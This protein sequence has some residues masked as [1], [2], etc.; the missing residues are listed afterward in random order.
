[1]YSD[2]FSNSDYAYDSNR[3]LFKTARP[4]T[5][6]ASVEPLADSDTGGIAP[7]TDGFLRTCKLALSQIDIPS[8]KIAAL[9][10]MSKRVSDDVFIQNLGWD[11]FVKKDFFD[12]IAKEAE[13]TQKLRWGGKISSRVL[14]YPCPLRMGTTIMNPRDTPSS[15]YL[16]TYS[17]MDYDNPYSY[18]SRS[19][20]LS[21]VY[22]DAISKNT[23]SILSHLRELFGGG[24]LGSLYEFHALSSLI[25]CSSFSFRYTDTLPED[26]ACDSKV[27]S[28]DRPTVHTYVRNI[29]SLKSCVYNNSWYLPNCRRFPIID[30]M[31]IS[32]DNVLMLLQVTRSL[33]HKIS[34]TYRHEFIKQVVDVA[35]TCQQDSTKQPLEQIVFV[36]FSTSDNFAMK[37]YE[38]FVTSLNEALESNDVAVRAHAGLHVQAINK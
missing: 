17:S 27:I 24:G 25:M 33:S 34:K 23:E 22:A 18:Y 14:E 20:F 26:E 13:S 4:S 7:S 36:I 9:G 1:M 29:K 6:L 32:D 19:T 37:N 38:D 10:N 12:S 16:Y 5:F 2:V 15:C 30:A 35:Q 21:C 28:F 8:L 11:Q 3:M 31:A